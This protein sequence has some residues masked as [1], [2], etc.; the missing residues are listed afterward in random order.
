[1][2]NEAKKVCELVKAGDVSGAEG[3]DRSAVLATEINLDAPRWT[4]ETEIPGAD[5]QK[6]LIKT[7]PLSFLLCVDN[8][9]KAE[10]KAKEYSRMLAVHLWAFATD[11]VDVN[12]F[13]ALMLV[14]K[15]EAGYTN[16][17]ETWRNYKSRI[18]THFANDQMPDPSDKML[19]PKLND[20]GKSTGDWSD[21]VER[22][23]TSM[24]EYYTYCKEAKKA[25]PKI[26]D[27]PK[28]IPSEVELGTSG[29]EVTPAAT[30][31]TEA[32]GSQTIE[33]EPDPFTI[34]LAELQTLF[35]QANTKEQQK[36]TKRIQS[37]INDI[38]KDQA[39]RF[40]AEEAA[41]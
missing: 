37:L 31:V 26:E 33:Q 10:A 38:K 20:K 39:A 9:G 23:P 36:I 11:C 34:R 27:K 5:G 17:P 1:M 18:V 21:L 19:L 2:T 41:A 32:D 8:L 28:S 12:E 16:W 14:L 13:E 35:A 25:K 15:H 24:H 6:H 7:D 4:I 40:E 22:E 29:V 3:I 30:V